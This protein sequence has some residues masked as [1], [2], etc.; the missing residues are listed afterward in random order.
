[1]SASTI[2]AH[3]YWGH[4]RRR[5]EG[6]R[7][8]QRTRQLKVTLLQRVG[9]L[10][11]QQRRHLRHMTPDGG[12]C[13]APV[14]VAG[15]YWTIGR[16]VCLNQWLSL[17]RHRQTEYSC[18]ALQLFRARNSPLASLTSNMV[19]ALSSLA[20]TCAPLQKSSF[21]NLHPTKRNGLKVSPAQTIRSRLNTARL[22]YIA[23]HQM[24]V[25]L[26]RSS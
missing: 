10:L 17:G 16:D 22:H 26:N 9:R 3:R 15:R 6:S 7:H 21:P 2:R 8:R 12:M 1:M 13:Y 19:H 24:S 18:E 14:A 5:S 23:T 20:D 4:L 11:K 25:T